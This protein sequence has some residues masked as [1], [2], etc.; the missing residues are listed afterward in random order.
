MKK[1]KSKRT[2][3]IIEKPIRRRY[4]IVNYDV[5]ENK[6]LLLFI[7]ETNNMSF[8]TIKMSSSIQTEA[9]A[10]EE[11]IYRAEWKNVSDLFNH[12]YLT[13]ADEEETKSSN[14]L[15]NEIR[16]EKNQMDLDDSVKYK[17][18]HCYQPFQAN[19]Q[20]CIGN[21]PG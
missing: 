11:V 17:C 9:T 5:V 2:F 21:Q 1:A 6:H 18:I 3:S 4:R 7:N 14:M 16:N 20:N 8:K 10:D 13:F 15:V 12:G 19:V